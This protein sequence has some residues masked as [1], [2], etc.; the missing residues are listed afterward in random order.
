MGIASALIAHGHVTCAKT[1]TTLIPRSRTI[2]GEQ[3]RGT[4]TPINPLV[5]IPILM[6]VIVIGFWAWMFRDMATNDD[7]PQD[8]KN[9][10]AFA[11]IFL[12]LFA[13]AYY[14]VNVYR[15]RG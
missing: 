3:K 11:F 1:S 5:V 2:T 10:W 12:S 15:N 9:V 4:M 7:L 6:T 13:A 14:Y 8:A